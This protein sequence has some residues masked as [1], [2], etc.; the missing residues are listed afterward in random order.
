MNKQLWK[1]SGLNVSRTIDESYLHAVNSLHS[2]GKDLTY[3]HKDY[4]EA[5]KNSSIT[6]T[7]FTSNSV[8]PEVLLA[9]FF[10]S[11]ILTIILI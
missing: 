10:I 9:I 5:S 6:H 3:N 11:A 7:K 1:D 4:I 2:E 8:E